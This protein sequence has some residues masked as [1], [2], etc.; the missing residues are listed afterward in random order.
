MSEKP[1]V[2]GFA[3]ALI[4]AADEGSKAKRLR[5]VADISLQIGQSGISPQ[6]MTSHDVTLAVLQER[7]T[8]GEVTG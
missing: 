2:E 1:P 7:A 8:A 4:A 5:M 6:T 3:D